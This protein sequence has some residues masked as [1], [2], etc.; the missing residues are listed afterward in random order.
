MNVTDQV[1]RSHELYGGSDSTNPAYYSSNRSLNYAKTSNSLLGAQVEKVTAI[2]LDVNYK[3]S[4]GLFGAENVFIKVQLDIENTISVIANNGI[5]INTY[6]P[7]RIDLKFEDNDLFYESAVMDYK[8]D[9]FEDN[10]Y[11][12]A[13]INNRLELIAQPLVS[14]DLNNLKTG[15]KYIDA[16]FD[17]R[18]Y[19]K[20]RIEFP[21]DKMYINP[22]SFFY[23]G[24]HARNT[25]RLPYN[26][27]M[28]VGN[29]FISEYDL[30]QSERRYIDPSN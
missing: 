8:K 22:K 28:T 20:D 21:Y 1:I 18:L 2:P 9:L 26:V 16:W 23:L 5:T 12:P 15:N 13:I 19:T 6:L 7:A 25:K 24:F 11:E 30:P 3:D 14:I 17:V 29:S 4:V 10:T 27:R